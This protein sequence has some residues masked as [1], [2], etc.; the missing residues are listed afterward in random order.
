MFS[1]IGPNRQF[2]QNFL[3]FN[4][5]NSFILQGRRRAGHGTDLRDADG[6]APT[7]SPTRCTALRRAAVR[8]SADGLT[9]QLPAAAAR[10][11]FHD[12]TPLTAA[13]CRVLADDR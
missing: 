13:R 10:R 1:Q 11:S 3:T 6:A 2:N 9:Y 8:I 12:G 7:T 5:L 4:S